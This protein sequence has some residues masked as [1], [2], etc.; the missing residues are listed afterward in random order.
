MLRADGLQ[1]VLASPHELRVE[2]R[3]AI[4]ALARW[5]A[6]AHGVTFL[7]QTLVRSVEPPNIETTR[8]ALRPQRMRRLPGRRFLGLFPERFASLRSDPLQAAHAACGA[9]H[10]RCRDSPPR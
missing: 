8:G 7:Y 10:R 9:P 1:A 2:S 5:L 6:E 4:P 3:T